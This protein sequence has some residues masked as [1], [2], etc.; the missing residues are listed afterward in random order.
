L[1]NSKLQAP[2]QR[3]HRTLTLTSAVQPSIH[4]FREC[5]HCQVFSVYPV[6]CVFICLMKSVKS[7]LWTR[8]DYGSP[9]SQSSSQQ[10]SWRLN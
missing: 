8:V 5:F 4:L 3:S 1:S 7:G 2:K 6:D 10:V 9:L